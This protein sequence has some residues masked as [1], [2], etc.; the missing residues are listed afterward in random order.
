MAKVIGVWIFK[1][2][3]DTSVSFNES[4]KFTSRNESWKEIAIEQDCLRY[5]DSFG[6]YNY[7]FMYGSQGNSYWS[8]EDFRTVNFGA[9]VQEVSS[10]FYE[11]LTA[12]AT[13]YIPDAAIITYNGTCINTLKHGQTVRLKCD[14]RIM[15]ADV[16]VE[17]L[18]DGYG[19][20]VNYL[21]KDVVVNPGQTA[22]FSCAGK[23]MYIRMEVAAITP[24]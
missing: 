13:L 18:A 24:E 3:V 17:A 23:R 11:W 14:G 16:V 10:D 4:V 5:T 19:V 7:V 8:K 2:K 1:E 22:T 12:N 6:F 9:K 15:L 21:G 20:V